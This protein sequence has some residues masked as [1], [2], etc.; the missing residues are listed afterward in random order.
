MTILDSQY[1]VY[2]NGFLDRESYE[3]NFVE[4]VRQFGPAW[5]NFDVRIIRTS[6]RNEV[7]RILATLAATEFAK[8]E[9]TIRSLQTERD[10]PYMGPLTAKAASGEDFDEA[11]RYRIARTILILI[12][13]LHSDYKQR[14]T[15]GL[16]LSSE[17]PQF[18]G[19]RGALQ[20]Y[21]ETVKAIWVQVHYT[22]DF[23]DW[24][25]TNI[26]GLSETGGQQ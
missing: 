22:R 21:R 7:E 16:D 18:A 12:V 24:V 6:F 4:G 14:R 2:Q 26:E 20:T 23:L 13:R 1:Y 17:T 10:S 25:E 3:T 9:L 5:K 19:L 8:D 15:L 11:D